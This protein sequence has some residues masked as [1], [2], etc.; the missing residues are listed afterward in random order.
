MFAAPVVLVEGVRYVTSFS[1]Y[2]VIWHASEERKRS[3]P[4]Q[5]SSFYPGEKILYASQT[6]RSDDKPC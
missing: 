4:T 5:G 3:E 6:A 1:S 2:V